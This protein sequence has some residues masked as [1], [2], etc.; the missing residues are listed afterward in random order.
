MSSFTQRSAFEH[1]EKKKKRLSSGSFAMEKDLRDRFIG[2]RRR[3]NEKERRIQRTDTLFD[4]ICEML[5]IASTSFRRRSSQKS[6]HWTSSVRGLI[7]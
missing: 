7:Q 2:D 6:D 3:Q 4:S 5:V 1:G